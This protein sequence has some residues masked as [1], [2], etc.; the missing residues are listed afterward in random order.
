LEEYVAWLASTM[1]E[2]TAHRETAHVK[3]AF[4][5]ALRVGLVET[6]VTP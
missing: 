4:R 1:A 3:A 6:D 5:Y 2:T